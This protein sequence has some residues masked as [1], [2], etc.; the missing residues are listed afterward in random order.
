M[1]Q[2]AAGP[3]AGGSAGTDISDH[4]LVTLYGA[5][6]EGYVRTE[7][8][9]R[10]DVVAGVDLPGPWF[11]VLLR[12]LRTPGHKLPMTRLAHDVSLTS[13]GFTKLADRMA[14][15]G[16]IDRQPCASDRRVTYTVLTPRGAR[17]AEEGHRRHA[18]L[19]R[20]HF[21]APLGAD[22]AE[23]LAALMRVLR[24][25]NSDPLQG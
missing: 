20:S 16:L 10:V 15:A 17:L 24:D 23:Q 13:G 19:L 2:Q 18:A 25:A 3:A 5:L 8:L 12:L 9:V 21:L 7:R 6:L 11:E 22:R 1:G 14:G 4:D